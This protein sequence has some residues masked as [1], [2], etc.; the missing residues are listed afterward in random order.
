MGQIWFGIFTVF[1]VSSGNPR[2]C[3]LIFGEFWIL[4]LFQ[5][6]FKNSPL[7][8][9]DDKIFLRL[10]KKKMMENVPI[11]PINFMNS[12]VFIKWTEMT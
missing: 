9:T 10:D 2:K 11:H 6:D 8:R 7:S 1:F 4:F 12:S 5:D 3:L